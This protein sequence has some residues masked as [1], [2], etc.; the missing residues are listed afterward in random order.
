MK[1][2]FDPA[3]YMVEE[4]G[5]VIFRVVLVGDTSVSVMGTFSTMDGTAVGES[6]THTH[7]CCHGNTAALSLQLLGTILLNLEGW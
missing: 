3:L 1:V 5:V 7:T 6:H 2:T 4:G